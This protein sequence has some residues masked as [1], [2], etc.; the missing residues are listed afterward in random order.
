MRYR[1]RAHRGQ[2]GAKTRHFGGCAKQK[3]VVS[4]ALLRSENTQEKENI[5]VGEGSYHVERSLDWEAA[6]TRDI[7]IGA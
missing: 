7:A 4:Q 1:P 3:A 2:G 6:R 5:G